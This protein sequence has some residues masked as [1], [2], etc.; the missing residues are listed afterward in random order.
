MR[1]HPAR[2]PSRCVTGEAG[3]RVNQSDLVFLGRVCEKADRP[4]YWKE[5]KETTANIDTVCWMLNM[6]LCL[7]GN[8]CLFEAEDFLC[9]CV[10]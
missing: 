4:R 6:F 9:V 2:L 1:K 3:C 5:K 10:V 7:M 8:V